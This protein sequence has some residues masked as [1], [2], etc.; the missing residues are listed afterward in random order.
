LTSLKNTFS[1]I[2]K[3]GVDDSQSP[4]EQRKIRTIN[5]L[6][7]I[8]L[9]FLLIGYTSFFILDKDFVIS[10]HTAF[11]ALTIVSL[12]LN[13]YKKTNSALF[14]FTL[15][16]NLSIF[17]INQYYPIETGSYLY[18]FPL[19]VSIVLLSN[20][21]FKDKFS[22]IYMA[23]CIIFFAIDLLFDFSDYAVQELTEAQIKQLWY[24]NVIISASV[25]AIL[26]ILLTRLIAKQNKDMIEQNDNLKKAKE[27]VNT[28]LKE[29]EILLAELHHRVKNNLAI[30]SALLNLQEDATS[31]EEAK[32]V[33]SD[34]KT[35][36]MSM[37]LVH[38][39][40]YENPEL[41][42]ID[43]GKY[44]SELIYE[45]FNSYNLSKS[46]L[47]TEEYDNIVLP[48]SKSVP[49]GLVLNEIVTNSIKYVFKYSPKNKGQF[50]V[51]LK[52]NNNMVKLI[53]KDN[54]SGFPAGF[55]PDSETVS[56]G[57]YLIKTLTEQVDGKVRF[58]NDMGAKI[59][60]DFTVN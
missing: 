48:V 8:V 51:S 42:S 36:I 41:K 56:L 27:T 44:A 17:F 57:I 6:N 24:Y 9:F 23:I 43:F 46:V 26:S 22:L 21:N 18:Y 37:A 5:F 50:Y 3:F 33:L 32:Q 2:L 30:I 15:N 11:I 39:M 16:A 55:D 1:T 58:S 10:I 54:G 34:S 29:K 31:S 13:K 14:V 53:V 40:L 59:E 45:L 25:T 19:I 4:H 35:R 28:S 52:Q 47:I 7:L 12:V 20:P 60:L 38:K 49:L